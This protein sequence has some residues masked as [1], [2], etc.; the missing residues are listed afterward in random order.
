MIFESNR[1]AKMNLFSSIFFLSNVYNSLNAMQLKDMYYTSYLPSC[2]SK[3][4]CDSELLHDVQ[5]ARLY[6]DSKEFVDKKMKYNESYTLEKYEELKIQNGRKTPS[7]E[8]LQKFV[9]EHFE[10]G[11][12]LEVW[13][14]PDFKE[15]I[16]LEERI[17]DT[18]YKKFAN[19]LNQIW[20]I[21]ARKVK[22]E[23]KE[24]S[25][26]YSLLYTPN[27][28]CI[29]GGR[30][31]ELYYWDTYWI[32]NGLILSDM[33]ETA[34]GVIENIVYLVNKYGI[35]PNGARV[36]YQRRSQPPFLI[37]MFESYYKATSDSK[38]VEKHLK[39]LTSEFEWW[40]NNRK[41]KFVKDNKRY[42]MYRYFAPS[43]G[44]RP[45]SYRED[46]ELAESIDTEIERERWYGRMK[47]GAESGWDFSSRW[48]I[49][50]NGGYNGTLLDVNTPSLVVTDLNA[51]MHKNAVFLS[52]WW[53]KMGDKYRSKL[54][55]EVADKQL[56][57]IEEV[58]WNEQRGCWFDYDLKSQ[59]PRDQFYPSNFAPLWTGSYTKPK[60]QVAT[61]IIE[62][63]KQE[64]MI[65]NELTARY[66]GQP[67]SKFESGQQWDQ[68][69]AWPPVQVF[70]IQGLDRTGVPQAQE[71]AYSFAQNWVH[72][73]YLGYKKAGFMFEKYH[74]RLAGETGGGG[75]YE[76]QTGFG[77][78]NGVVFE[79]LDRYSDRLT[80]NYKFEVQ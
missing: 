70:L 2:D 39:T 10:D 36:Y 57:S 75:E 23:V 53:G 55:K 4:Y 51:V 16:S 58:L 34:R 28:F 21:L 24:K 12:E 32:V 33:V 77:W 66:H 8:Q 7:K 56:A 9:Y 52:E 26:Q 48:F 14:P 22:V 18:E 45:E 61:R 19:G 73:N 3:V 6:P 1:T 63:V 64:E 72:T 13:V 20:K 40:Q 29:P 35:M 78:T 44:P 15:H 11:N 50:K 68:P 43:N 42:E 5:M 27:G 80:A 47:S 49:N 60:I 65:T 31:R 25:D 41:V 37:L 30:F 67:C 69:N 38:F 76:P 62:Y 59:K 79:M 71:V 17:R 74:I 54:Y 46:Y